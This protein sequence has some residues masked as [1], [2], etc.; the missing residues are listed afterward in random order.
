MSAVVL[1]GLV[2]SWSLPVLHPAQ[3]LLDAREP[4]ASGF[5][6]AAVLT[7]RQMFRTV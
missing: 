2:M 6:D 1:A 4:F 3:W 5:I 7:A